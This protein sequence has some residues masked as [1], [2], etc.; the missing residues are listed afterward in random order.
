[1]VMDENTKI[2]IITLGSTLIGAFVTIALA[3]IAARW[4]KTP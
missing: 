4:H 2:T 1:M 3:Y